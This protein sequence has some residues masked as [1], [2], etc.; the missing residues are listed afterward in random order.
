MRTALFPLQKAVYTRLST[1]QPLLDR[2]TGVFDMVPEGQ[3]LPYCTVGE[4][5]VTPSDTKL[6]VGEN[7]LM[8]IHAWSGYEGKKEVYEL[9]SLM[10]E[11]LSSAQLSVDG[12][13]LY[14][15][16]REQLNVI[17]DIDG[18]TKH[19]FIDLRFFINN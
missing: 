6:T 5:I 9:L 7:I 10:L 16:E 12:F 15:F 8:T 1:Y 14:H 3:Q 13:R 11:A 19:G 4:C 2:I 17:T 18:L